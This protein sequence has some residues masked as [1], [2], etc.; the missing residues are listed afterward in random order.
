MSCA[1]NQENLDRDIFS[2]ENNF[3][4]DESDSNSSEN[5]KQRK[6]KNLRLTKMT[7]GGSQSSFRR[8]MGGINSVKKS[9]GYSGN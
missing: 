6:L 1:L 2:Y 3:Q 7:S 8:L 4:K 9:F 5:F